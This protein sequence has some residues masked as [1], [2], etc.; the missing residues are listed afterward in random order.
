MATAKEG[1]SSTITSAS[2]YRTAAKRMLAHTS[3]IAALRAES[4]NLAAAYGID[5]AQP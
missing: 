5:L 3:A 2:A 1:L 4:A